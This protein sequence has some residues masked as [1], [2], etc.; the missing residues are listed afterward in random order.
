M[1]DKFTCFSSENISLKVSGRC[2]L[3]R[4]KVIVIELILLICC[5]T[6]RR[7]VA[8]QPEVV[9]VD[10]LKSLLTLTRERFLDH[11]DAFIPKTIQRKTDK[12]N[13]SNPL[14]GKSFCYC[15][16]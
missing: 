11:F 6:E 16:Y 5:L 2:A 3:E 10:E 8:E 9:S 7:K 1:L 12:I 14:N 4:I 15:K 13:T